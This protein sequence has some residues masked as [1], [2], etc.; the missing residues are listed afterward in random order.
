MRTG[1][2]SEAHSGQK[3]G[4]RVAGYFRLRNKTT[5]QRVD[6]ALFAYED[7]NDVAT[8]SYRQLKQYAL[9]CWDFIR[10]DAK[11]TGAAQKLV[12]AKCDWVYLLA[13]I[14]NYCSFFSP[15]F[16]ETERNRQEK[17]FT[18]SRRIG[19]FASRIP[20]LKKQ[21]CDLNREI[22]EQ[23][24]IDAESHA[25]DFSLYD[26]VLALAQTQTLPSKNRLNLDK[27]QLMFLC[28]LITS[29][30]GKQ[31]LSKLADL[32]RARTGMQVGADTLRVQ[33][34]RAIKARK[35]LS[36]Q[37]E[38][39]ARAIIRRSPYWRCSPLPHPKQG[40]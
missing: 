29:A 8:I 38:K 27:A 13:S 11:A 7:K 35:Q 30:T 10:R 4:A 31:H 34:T 14:E 32:I 25:P 26:G 28:H 17:L 20:R 36:D 40:T 24:G 37:F 23:T 5:G 16:Q 33:L 39:D 2:R 19:D 9:T 1:R 15:E 22:R 18:L 21:I 12:E 6:V 3:R